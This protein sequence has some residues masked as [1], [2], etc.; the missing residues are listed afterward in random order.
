L[1]D[2]AT[3]ALVKS[4]DDILRLQEDTD[5]SAL[6]ELKQKLRRSAG[7]AERGELVDGE[8]F[9]DQLIARLRAKGAGRGPDSGDRDR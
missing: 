8:E 9:L 1:R 4:Y 5:D 6:E 2:R 7:E 3:I